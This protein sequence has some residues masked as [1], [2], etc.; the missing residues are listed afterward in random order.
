MMQGQGQVSNPVSRRGFQNRGLLGDITNESEEASKE[1]K[2][3]DIQ[4]EESSNAD[5]TYDQENIGAE[6]TANDISSSK[7]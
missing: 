5:R 6:R 3:K 1:D 4:E 7:H 2:F